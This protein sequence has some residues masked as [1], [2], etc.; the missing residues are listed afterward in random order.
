[1]AVRFLDTPASPETVLEPFQLGPWFR[2]RFGEPTLVQRLAW[3]AFSMPGHVLIS[4]PT[5]TGKTLAALI[6]I[7]EQLLLPWT[8]TGWS[9][10]PLRVLYLAPLK[11]L[12]ND[13]ARSLEMHL[14]DLA[15][16]MPG[17]A[18]PTLGLRTG[19]TSAQDRKKQRDEPPTIL[20][21]TPESLAVM[22]THPSCA[23]L[24][25]NLG[26]IIVDE[27]H[28]L[29]STKRGADLA[30]SLERVT[31]LATGL[32][33]RRLG[34]SATALP[35]DLTARWLAGPERECVIVRAPRESIPVLRIEPLPPDA[36]FLTG[37][38]DRLAREIPAHRA[39]LVFTNTR[40]LA[41]RLGWSLRRK[42]PDLDSKVAVHHSSLSAS[43][44]REVE[45][46]FKTGLL[47]V[48]ISSTS[49]ELGIDIGRV[50]L[51]VLVHPPGD[52]VRLLQRIGRAG[53]EPGVASQGLV[54]AATASEL[55]EAA[56]TAASGRQEQCEPLS[57]PDAP[58]D[59]L[60][61][62]LL[63]MTCTRSWD[64]DDL[65]A[66]VRKAAPYAGLERGDFDACLGYLRGLDSEGRSWLP[67]RVREDGDCWRVRDA[68]TVRLLRRNLGTILAEQG[69]EVQTLASEPGTVQPS[70]PDSGEITQATLTIGQIDEAYAD[71]LQAGDRFLLDGRCL[72]VRR[73][74]DQ[75]LLVNEVPGRPR[76]PRWGGD[77]LPLSSQL[78]RRLYTLR[79]AAAEALTDG[80]EALANLLRTDYH[81]DGPAIT[82]L[83]ELFQQ[84]EGISEIPDL[85]TLL[86]E[87]VH[88]QGAVDCYLHTPL[89]RAGNDALARVA[90]MRLARDRGRSSSSFVADLGLCLRL[91]AEIPDMPQ[92]V[93]ELFALAGFEADLDE[94]LAASESL[95]TRFARVAQTGLM[96][97]R[98]P[99]RRRRKVGGP[100]WGQR[101]LF[102]R[103]RQRDPD[104][105]LMRQALREVRENL[106]DA[107]TARAYVEHLPRLGVRCRWLPAPSPFAAAW[108][109]WEAGELGSGETPGDALRRLHAE[110]TGG[111]GAR[112]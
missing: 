107:V 51:V 63:G 69:V 46:H 90:V 77:G 26:W 103:I 52:V 11:A 84:Q 58:L 40:A 98:N 28:A 32:E 82:T 111:G 48:V 85:N 19:D 50:D 44:R 110:L 23:R 14:E 112:S 65:Y 17:A 8:P 71:R 42:L 30:L 24:F 87:I 66:L 61:Q 97:L 18:L 33:P 67:A 55:L 49:L 37:L 83:V 101:Q 74:Q 80:P 95:R 15:G 27:V 22:L 89:N 36:R 105:V 39:I 75:T 2:E 45:R 5:G 76:V 4:A 96:L 9:D 78:A 93:R 1:M 10:S 53:H 70:T 109:Q 54:L 86:I 41:E 81:L 59:V 104:F 34:L 3:P 20:F 94:A 57:V 88:D 29:A 7:L 25:A 99:E 21:T 60:G 79:V 106:C 91:R 68:K 16:A 72:E 47:R 12:V 43:R 92:V 73:R 108:T 62:Q 35:L 38:V 64:A 102:D 100:L 31:A 6:P 13:A 56:V